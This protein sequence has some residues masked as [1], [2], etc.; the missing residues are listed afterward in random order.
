MRKI[1]LGRTNL[2]ATE[3]SF[4]A[5]PIQRIPKEDAAQLL[6]LAYDRGV[7]FFD[8]A[9]FYTDS[10]EKIGYALSDVRDKIIIATK[11]ATD[12][13]AFMQKNLEQSLR[14]LKTDY[15]D[16]YQ[17]HNPAKLPNDDILNFLYKA[18]RDGKIRHIGFTNHRIGLA[19]SALDT[20]IFDTMQFPFSLLAGDCDIELVRRCE[21]ED[22]GF[23]AMKAMAGGL[24]SDPAATF[25]YISQFKNVVPIFGVQRKEELLEFLGYAENP[26]AYDDAMR[27]RIEE[28][29]KDLSGDFCHGCGYCQPCPVGIEIWQCAR[30]SL[31]MKRMPT[32]PWVSDEWKAE[33]EKIKDCKNCGLCKSRCPYG[34]DTPGLLRR[35]LSRY[36]ELY[37]SLR[38]DKQ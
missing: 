1:R 11:S 8:T 7:N 22:V 27:A 9:N 34:L 15:I 3:V 30:I 19:N 21:R 32:G 17:L 31:M 26:P 28:Q 12:S 14:S 4:G 13:L 16:I 23:I 20:G 38:G 33:M 36:Y 5:L 24:I 2:F 6:R 18:K 10:E 29:K 25:T 35:E 37:E